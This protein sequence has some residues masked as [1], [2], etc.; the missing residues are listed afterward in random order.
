MRLFL[1]AL[2]VTA[3]GSTST[4]P[5]LDMSKY[6]TSCQAD[7]D[8]VFVSFADPCSS[9]RCPGTPISTSSLAQFNADEQNAARLCFSVN[10]GPVC[11]CPIAITS[12]DGGLCQA[13][14]ACH[15]GQCTTAAG[16][17]L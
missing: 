16:R 13:L 1:L 6:S 15:S 9:C 12:C 11:E 14:P 2:A 4:S 8:C 17:A 3:C 5:M 7:S 10:R